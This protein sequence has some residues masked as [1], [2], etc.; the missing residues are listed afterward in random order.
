MYRKKAEN[1]YLGTLKNSYR[2]KKKNPVSKFKID[3]NP[4]S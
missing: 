2:L 3:M 4:E 1:K